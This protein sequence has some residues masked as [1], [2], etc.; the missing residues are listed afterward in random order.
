MLPLGQ[1]AQT[2]RTTGA[3]CQRPGA[4]GLSVGDDVAAGEP[5]HQRARAQGATVHES[6]VQLAI[7][8]HHGDGGR[9]VAHI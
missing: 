1:V 4:M 7:S 8:R 2:T 9:C 5:V 6:R 3:A